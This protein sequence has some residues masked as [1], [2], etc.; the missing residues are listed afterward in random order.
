MDIIIVDI[1]DKIINNFQ[2]FKKNVVNY[3]KK[4]ELFYKK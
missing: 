4:L 3:F 2:Y 1:D